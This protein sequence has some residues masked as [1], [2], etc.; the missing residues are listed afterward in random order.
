MAVTITARRPARSLSYPAGFSHATCGC[1]GC[2]GVKGDCI[3]AVVTDVLYVRGAAAG[4]QASALVA[5]NATDLEIEAALT[6]AAALA[7]P[8]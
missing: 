3:Q 5:P 1:D 4:V 2:R 6:A 8:L 7:P